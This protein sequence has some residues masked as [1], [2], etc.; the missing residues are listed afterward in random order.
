[1]SVEDE[2]FFRKSLNLPSHLQTLMPWNG[3]TL[4]HY[5]GYNGYH[6]AHPNSITWHITQ[7]NGQGIHHSIVQ[8]EKLVICRCSGFAQ[9]RLIKVIPVQIELKETCCQQ[10]LLKQQSPHFFSE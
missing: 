7:Y 2:F 8:K 9:R 5:V 3:F 6:L 10:N 1:M 4:A